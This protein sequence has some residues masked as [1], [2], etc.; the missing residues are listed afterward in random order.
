MTEL[1]YQ[2]DSYRK[3]FEAVVEAVEGDRV[4]LDRTAF[5]PT[6]GGQPHDLG[7]LYAGTREIAV[8]QVAR[9]GAQVWHTVPEH[10]LN[11]GESV[12]GALDWGRRHQLMRTHTALHI[13][14]AVMW[15]DFAA[16]VTGGNMEPLQGRLDFELAEIPPDF[17]AHVEAAVNVEVR[18]ER[19]V[20]V[21]ILPRDEARRIPDLI[22]TKVDLLPRDIEQIRTV[23]IVGLDLQA[24]GGTHVRNTREVGGVRVVEYKSKGKAFKRIRI[25]VT[26][27]PSG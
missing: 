20:E 7:W 8:T 16:P 5:Y 12:R 3:E 18:A 13:L 26:D 2:T 1:L 15:R 6:G 19:P 4:G 24:D 27:A 11:S 17:T 9:E 25:E 22:R 10:G 14:S 23:H 21:R